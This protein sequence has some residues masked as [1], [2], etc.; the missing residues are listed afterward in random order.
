MRESDDHRFAD[1]IR[2]FQLFDRHEKGIHVN[3][4]DAAIGMLLRSFPPARSSLEIAP[5]RESATGL[6]GVN[7]TGGHSNSMIVPGTDS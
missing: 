1:Q 2:P 5:G 4:Q 3:V 6:L 7:C